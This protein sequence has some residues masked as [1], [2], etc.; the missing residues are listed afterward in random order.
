[1]STN[2]LSFDSANFALQQQRNCMNLD[3]RQPFNLYQK[4]KGADDRCF[5][6]VK[7]VQSLGPGQYQTMNFYDCECGIPKTTEVATSLP[8]VFFK[9]GVDV[10]GCVID[11]ATDLRVGKV[12]RFPKCRQQLFERPYATTPNLSR[13]PGNTMLESQLLPGE[14]TA[15]KRQCNTL[16]GVF[17]PQQYTPLVPNLQYNVQNPVHLIDEVGLGTVHGGAPSRLVVRDIDY[18]ERCGYQYMN[19]VMNDDFWR[20]KHNFL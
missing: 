15:E 7:T 10:G 13:G 19:K 3:G 11:Q 16:S 9:N 1:M 14:A 6:E 2:V 5:V 12:R 18:L 4:T 20:N 8:T 17:I